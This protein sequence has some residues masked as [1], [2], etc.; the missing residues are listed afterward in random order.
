MID[1]LRLSL[2]EMRRASN[3]RRILLVLSDGGDKNS[4]YSEAELLAELPDA[5]ERLSLQ[6][7]NEY[8][9]GYFS[10]HTPNDGRYHKVR[11][12]VQPPPEMKQVRATWRQ[13]YI[14]P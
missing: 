6:I 4:R 7:R 13:G 12:E 3:P 2:E 8:V 14:A 11:I 9:V 1:G 5:M 10:N